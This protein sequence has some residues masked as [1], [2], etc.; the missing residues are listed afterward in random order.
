MDCKRSRNAINTAKFRLNTLAI[1]AH[2]WQIQAFR[3]QSLNRTVTAST[4][5]FN[6]TRQSYKFAPLL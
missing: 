2:G 3:L 5:L 6:Q 1:L 4:S